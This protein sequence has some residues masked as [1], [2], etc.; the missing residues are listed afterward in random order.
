MVL[1]LIHNQSLQCD[2]FSCM[3]SGEATV[4]IYTQ[5][6]KYGHREASHG[7][8]AYIADLKKRFVHYWILKWIK[9][10]K[11]LGIK[12]KSKGKKAF[13]SRKQ[14]PKLMNSLIMREPHRQ[15]QSYQ[16]NCLW[17]SQRGQMLPSEYYRQEH[18]TWVPYF[19]VPFR[20][21]TKGQSKEVKPDRNSTWTLL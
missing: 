13:S 2:P 15:M 14:P 17:S 12:D 16:H 3:S 21:H 20:N 9:V 19:T 11:F 8:N 18:S 1:I 10:N 4:V 7:V 6:N 5:K